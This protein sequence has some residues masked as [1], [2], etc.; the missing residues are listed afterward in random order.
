[1]SVV[2]LSSYDSEILVL[3][4]RRAS[5]TFTKL[6]WSQTPT[7][8]SKTTTGDG[9]LLLLSRSRSSRS[10]LL[11]GTSSRDMENYPNDSTIDMSTRRTIKFHQP[12]GNCEYKNFEEDVLRRMD[13]LTVYAYSLRLNL[14]P[15]CFQSAFTTLETNP[16]TRP[17]SYQKLALYKSIT[18]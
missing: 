3:L 11:L 9:G 17:D 10:A 2:D 13:V 14:K 12:N 4:T 15:H 16:Q 18:Y 1:M 5:S 7:T 6:R 8:S